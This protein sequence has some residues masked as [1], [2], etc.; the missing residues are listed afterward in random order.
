MHDLLDVFKE[1]YLRGLRD[2]HT[3][4][5]GITYMQMIAHMYTNYGIITVADIM[6]N[7]KHINAPYHPSI[8]IESDLNQVEDAIEFAEAG[9]SPFSTTQ[10]TTKAFIQFFSTGLFRDEY[11]AWNHLVTP[12]RTWAMFD[13]IFTEVARDLREIYALTYNTGYVNKVAQE[14]MD[15]TT[16]AFIT[17]DTAT[18]EDMQTV[19]NVTTVNEILKA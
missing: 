19:A 18:A 8:E 7:E 10:I 9:N 13:L 6:K 3:G 15:Q 12:S 2:R 11:K 14:L 5:T 16:L 4:F 17:L 1:I